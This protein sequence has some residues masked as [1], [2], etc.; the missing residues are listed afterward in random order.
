MS[1][2]FPLLNIRIIAI[3]KDKNEWLVG[4]CA[5]Y[6]KL[7][8]RWCRLS[9]KILASPK[10]AAS[11]SPLEIRRLE[12]RLIEKEL[13]RGTVIALVDTG[14]KLDSIAF[15]Q[16]LEKLPATSPG[17]MTFVIG[18]PYGLDEAIL[19]RADRCLSLSPLTFSHQLVRLV[20][21]EQL[22]RGLSILHG[23]DYHK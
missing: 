22:Y 23:T 18:G 15:A 8:T 5:H 21:L 12:A 11:L 17:P 4:G 16:W 1:R 3:G 2:S 9:W 14:D 6:E 13:E 7:L 20:L 19:K 10:K